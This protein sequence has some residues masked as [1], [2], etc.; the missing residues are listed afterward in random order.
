MSAAA[1]R[2]LELHL[3]HVG[4][5]PGVAVHEG[6]VAAVADGGADHQQGRAAPPPG[7]GPGP[8]PEQPRSPRSAPTAVDDDPG[9]G[10]VRLVLP[11][12]ELVQRALAEV[13]LRGPG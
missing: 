13:L 7:R 3:A 8:P 11:P 1:D 4:T 5:Q 6:V 2:D 12:Q 9:L 10:E